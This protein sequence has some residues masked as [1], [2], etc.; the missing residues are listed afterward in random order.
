MAL[1]DFDTSTHTWSD[2][3]S[4]T[5]TVGSVTFR[6]P[7]KEEWSAFGGQLIIT[8][9]GYLFSGLS[10]SYWSSTEYDSSSAWYATFENGYMYHNNK[11]NGYS[12]RLCA[13]F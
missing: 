3:C 1:S 6:L 4:K 11:T 9:I 5:Q 13:T 10:R 8:S 12:V 2:A 7:S